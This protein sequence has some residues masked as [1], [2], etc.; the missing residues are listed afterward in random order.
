[1][2]SISYSLLRTGE[3]SEFSSSARRLRGGGGCPK[4]AGSSESEKGGDLEI[5]RAEG[6]KEGYEITI[7]SIV[8]GK[9]RRK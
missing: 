2:G 6:R 3:R 5:G 9:T 7:F 4:R 8:K 1:M